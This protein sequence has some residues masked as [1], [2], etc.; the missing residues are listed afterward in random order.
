M[1][2]SFARNSLLGGISGIA[3]ALGNFGTSV[4]LARLLGAEG[5][6]AVMFA[7][8]IVVVGA[9][10]ADL[11]SSIALSRYLPELEADG[12][13]AEAGAV[14]RFLFRPFSAA[15][16]ALF[17]ALA[18]YG[19]WH[20][21]AGRIPSTGQE[22]LAPHAN[23]AF[24]LLTA[25]ALALQA[26]A[27]FGY[28]FLRG[29]QRFGEVATLTLICLGLQLAG[30]T[31][32]SLAYGPL[33]ALGGYCLGFL[34]P[35]ALAFRHL[36]GGGAID[37]VLKRR[38]RR[39][40]L[41]AW[42]GNLSIVL[43]Y[44]RM[45]ILFLER[46]WGVEAVGLFAI[47]VTLA[48]IAAQGP[49][50]LT[51]GLLPHFSTSFGRGDRDAIQR[52]YTSGTR[53]MALLMFPA[54]LGLAALL[55]SLIPLI[56][57]PQFMPAIPA[58]VILAVSSAGGVMYVG[59]QLAL[60]CD[61]SELGLVTSLTGAVLLALGCLIVVPAFGILGAAVVRAAVQA[62]LIV[63]QFWLIRNRLG[64]RAPIPHLIRIFI[65]AGACGAAAWLVT[66]A[67]PT[68]AGLIG[69]VVVGALVFGLAVR[70]LDALPPEDVERIR[71]LSVRLPGGATRPI[72]WLLALIARDHRA[73]SAA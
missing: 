48:N 67:V 58:A 9:A 21:H 5:L 66:R 63:L 70:L 51:S 69:A 46:S 41:F 42:A 57:G 36:G 23:L 35:A 37:H 7:V 60:G 25:T 47:G 33:G 53:V 6:G 62:I 59:A 50:L 10:M 28:G 55:P 18:A 40:A 71:G 24:W 22:T 30:V 8:W 3:T 29:A 12:R 45:E 64:F 49:M 39:Y 16:A 14:A 68:P 13:R 38:M 56:Y 1:A 4:I 44:S 65:A 19:L 26:L 52:L 32:G 31:M 17:L 73:K 2:S 54:C 72:G 43:L 11:G 27:Q 15:V 34:L 20:W 61:R